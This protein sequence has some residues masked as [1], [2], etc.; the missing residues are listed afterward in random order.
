MS[1]LYDPVAI[2]N[3]QR[4]FGD[5]VTFCKDE[6]DAALNA[7]AIV[8]VTEWKQFRFV[9][10]HRIVPRLRQKALF[11]GRNQ[12]QLS[13]M[14]ALGLEYFGIGVPSSQALGCDLVGSG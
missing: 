14:E 9:D 10:F 3:T 1:A 6:Y 2:P 5:K 13:E 11:D 12:Y 7:D 8:L 4:I